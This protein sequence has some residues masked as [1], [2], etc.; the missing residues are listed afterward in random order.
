MAN[1][2][3]YLNKILLARYGK[4]VRGSIHDAIQ[5]MNTQVEDS[6]TSAGRSA[7]SAAESAEKAK[8]SAESIGNAEEVVL[9]YA[10]AA[11]ES[12]TEASNSADSASISAKSSLE[13]A[14]LAS[15]SEQEATAKASEASESAANARQSESNAENYATNASNSA[16]SASISASTA[17]DKATEASESATQASESAGNADSSANDSSTYATQSK[18]YAAGGTGTRTGEDTDNA[19]YYNEQAQKALSEMQKSQV[20]GVKG[21]EETEY[22]TGEV[23]ITA[24]NVGAVKTGGDVAENTVTYESNDCGPDGDPA[25][26]E[27]PKLTAGEKLSSIMQKVSRIA[28]NFRYMIKLLGKT[29]ISAIGDGTVTGSLVALNDNLWIQLTTQPKSD[30]NSILEIAKSIPNDKSRIYNILS[31]FTDYPPIMTAMGYTV[32]PVVRITSKGS[33]KYI[34]VIACDANGYTKIINGYTTTDL[35]TIL[36]QMDINIL[37][38]LHLQATNTTDSPSIFTA[39]VPDKYKN[40]SG[41]MYAISQ[42]IGNWGTWSVCNTDISNGVIKITTNYSGSSVFSPWFSILLFY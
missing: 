27:I 6:E 10:N 12:A 26:L 22:R 3:E 33:V 17:N 40:V 5:A 21:N 41:L 35:S 9:Q 42:V 2:Q 24:E 18:S 28:N 1:I 16:A 31:T 14:N 37:H 4:E 15:A 19:K 39:N 29:D 20:T 25:L 11:Q 36:W 30:Y 7:I 8:E 13:S 23:N 34:E 38:A 32:Y